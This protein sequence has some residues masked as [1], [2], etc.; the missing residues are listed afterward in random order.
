MPSDA[1]LKTMNALH[2]VFL[3]IGLFKTGM[4]MPVLELTTIGR[5]SGQPRAVMLTAPV[6]EGDNVVIVASKGGNDE[7]PA[8]YLNLRDNPDVKVSMGG[9]GNPKPYKAT[10]ADE[11][12]RARLWPKITADHKNY[13]G[14]QKKTDREIPVVVL[15]PA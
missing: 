14:Y 3:K 4:G 12:E 1:A 8:W 9:P 13:A 15:S 2:R 6:V 5:K 7:H 10:I 11:A